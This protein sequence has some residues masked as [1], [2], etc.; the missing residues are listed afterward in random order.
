[1]AS[2]GAIGDRPRLDYFAAI[3]DGPSTLRRVVDLIDA[4]GPHIASPVGRVLVT[5]VVLGQK[6]LGAF[7][8]LQEDRGARVC[9]DSGGYYV[10]VGKIAYEDLYLRL[11]GVY[12]AHPWADCFVL[13][14]NVPTSRDT[15]DDVWAKVRQT[16]RWSR[17][18][19]QE[20]PSA[21]QERA[22]PVVHGHTIEQVDYALSHYVDIG[23]RRIGF[24]SFGTFGKNEGVD[25]AHASSVA[26]ARWV[27]AAAARHGIAAHLFGLGVP[28][29][30]AMIAGL[31]AASFDSSGWLKAA[32][33][34]QVTLPFSR[35]YNITHR[36]SRSDLQAGILWE[37]FLANK[38]RTGH[39]CPYCERRD[40]LAACKWRR[41]AHNLIALS[42]SV[43][44]INRQEYERIRDIYAGGSPRYRSEGERW[45]PNG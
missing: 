2:A 4:A 8:R 39:R 27:I 28:A 15:P 22:M 37:A 29:L 38:E 18:F 40:T 45:L 33:F 16:V 44:M 24:G 1:S 25:I 21:L 41:A 42:E 11:L 13:P 20:L 6:S 36:N 34:G 10:Q 17:M 30:V 26:V 12:R 32:G 31:G 35:A 5:P 19:F 9:F 43:A 3:T 23:A 14:D 7:R